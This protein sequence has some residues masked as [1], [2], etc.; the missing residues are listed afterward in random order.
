MVVMNLSLKNIY[1]FTDFEI[2]FSYP[3]KIVNSLIEDEHLPGRFLPV[4]EGCYSHGRERHW[5]D[6]PGQI[7]AQNVQ[8]PRIWKH[9]A[10]V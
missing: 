3:K 8:V 10:S 1:G 4:Q 9:G 7:L 2:N 6:Q 5:Q